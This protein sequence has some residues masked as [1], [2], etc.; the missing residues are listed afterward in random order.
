MLG[1]LVVR[2]FNGSTKPAASP[3]S[4]QS[5]GNH[6]AD[7]VSPTSELSDGKSSTKTTSLHTEIIKSLSKLPPKPRK[8]AE[9]TPQQARPKA[10]KWEEPTSAVWTV[11]ELK[12]RFGKYIEGIDGASFKV[13]RSPSSNLQVRFYFETE[14][15]REQLIE[16]V[17]QWPTDQQCKKVYGKFTPEMPEYAWQK[18]S[19]EG[20]FTFT[21]NSAQT[22]YMA[23]IQ[24]GKDAFFRQLINELFTSFN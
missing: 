13:V 5:K 19:E 24:W 8:D 6:S 11:T 14:E 20:K 16:R 7:S 17:N 10:E 12:T 22:Q 23:K 4:K 2:Y 1:I 9:S 18:G 21:L 15:S 3:P